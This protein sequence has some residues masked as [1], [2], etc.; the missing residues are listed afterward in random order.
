MISSEPWYGVRLLYRLTGT[1]K[2]AYEERILIIP[3]LSSASAIAE[4]NSISER[5]YEDETVERLD[6]AMGFNIFDHSGAYLESGTEV[7]SLI[8]LSDLT[9][10]QYIDRF[11]STGEECCQEIEET[12]SYNKDEIG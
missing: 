6:Y 3:A 4:A 7:F 10:D 11:H 9:T 12:P 8:R 5:D 1:V 2:P